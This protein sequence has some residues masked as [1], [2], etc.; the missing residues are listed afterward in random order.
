VNGIINRGIQDPVETACGAEAWAKIKSP[1]R[2]DAP[3]FAISRDYPDETTLALVEA[4]AEVAGPPIEAVMVEY[5]TFIVPNAL[6]GALPD[7]S[8]CECAGAHE[9]VH[10][11][12]A[13]TWWSNVPI[14][15]LRGRVWRTA[16]GGGV[17]CR[18]QE[19][20]GESR[21]APY[22]LRHNARQGQRA[23]RLAF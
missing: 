23:E 10:G 9:S 22:G 4:A 5:G 7:L 12:P 19:S 1:A 13:L 15:R 20:G 11:Q 8:D 6:R 2:C 14:P 17:P 21:V 18:P 16:S 3:L